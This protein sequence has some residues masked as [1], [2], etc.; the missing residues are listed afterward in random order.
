MPITRG[1]MCSYRWKWMWTHLTYRSML[2]ITNTSFHRYYLNS[3]IKSQFSTFTNDAT[4]LHSQHIF[5]W[6][7]FFE[8]G[9]CW[10]EGQH[11]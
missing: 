2:H 5:L 10:L 8:N 9:S 6:E 3:L 11:I 1:I 4:F 7:G